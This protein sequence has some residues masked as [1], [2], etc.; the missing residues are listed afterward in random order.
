MRC[1]WLPGP[2]IENR[3]EKRVEFRAFRR[4]TE[5]VREWISLD[6]RTPSSNTNRRPFA[7]ANKWP[8][9]N[10]TPPGHVD[11]DKETLLIARNWWRKSHRQVNSN[12]SAAVVNRWFLMSNHEYLTSIFAL[13]HIKIEIDNITD[14]KDDYCYWLAGVGFCSFAKSMKFLKESLNDSIRS[15]GGKAPRKRIVKES[16]CKSSNN[17]QRSPEEYIKSFPVD[18]DLMPKLTIQQ[19]V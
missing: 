5:W 17:S 3:L 12:S 11:V 9:L 10:S 19:S 13:P 8:T 2:R 15:R 16:A 7:T 6:T 18:V 4:E 14:D 1:N